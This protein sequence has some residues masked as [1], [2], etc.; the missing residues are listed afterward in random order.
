VRIRAGARA[1][2]NGQ[3]ADLMT[4]HAFGPKSR[5]TRRTVQ[6]L[7][8]PR[9][10]TLTKPRPAGRRASVHDA[11]RPRGNRAR[12]MHVTVGGHRGVTRWPPDLWDI[13]IHVFGIK[14]QDK[15]STCQICSQLERKTKRG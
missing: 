10:V 6:T 12:A 2:A 15:A 11:R 8:S 3:T 13:T 4:H 14:P 7:R 9:S 5:R 1:T